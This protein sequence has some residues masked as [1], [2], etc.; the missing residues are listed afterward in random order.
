MEG[1]SGLSPM[2]YTLV[3]RPHYQTHFNWRDHL[4]YSGLQT[5]AWENESPIIHPTTFAPSTTIAFGLDTA[6][7]GC[8]HNWGGFGGGA[9]C[10]DG[11]CSDDMRYGWE[12]DGRVKDGDLYHLI[13]RYDQLWKMV[14]FTDASIVQIEFGNID[15]RRIRW[16]LNGVDPVDPIIGDGVVSFDGRK[17]CIHSTLAAP[18]IKTIPSGNDDDLVSTYLDYTSR[19][20]D[21]VAFS[22][23][24]F[25]FE[26]DT[27]A[28]NGALT[29][30][31]VSGR[32]SIQ[33]AENFFESNNAANTR[34][35]SYHLCAKTVFTPS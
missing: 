20:F 8:S 15:Q 32:Y 9:K 18:E 17:G 4:P 3:R 11:W 34:H 19:G 35:D 31:D 14:F 13:A 7:Q 28:D 30:S 5:W 27:L 22:N 23:K 16:T 2:K 29:F 6:R 21:C 10:I 12:H 25:Q 33:L 24:T 1:T 26:T